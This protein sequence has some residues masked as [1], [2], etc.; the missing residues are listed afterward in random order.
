[1]WAGDA[2]VAFSMSFV[3]FHIADQVYKKN[4]LPK[5]NQN[6]IFAC[7]IK[8]FTFDFQTQIFRVMRRRAVVVPFYQIRTHHQV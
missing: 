3:F 2:F 8:I 6:K 7:Q 1:M 5:K 4:T